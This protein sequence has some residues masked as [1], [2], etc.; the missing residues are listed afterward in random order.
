MPRKPENLETLRL[1]LELLQRIPRRGKITAKELHQ[2]INGAGIQR[3]TR[4]IQR[5][6]KMLTESF[7]IESDGAKPA[8]YRWKTHA[9]GMTVAAMS[10][11]QALLL[12]LAQQHLRLL[13]PAKV[14]EAMAQFF[15]QAQRN[16]DPFGDGKL[17]RQWLSKVRVVSEGVQLLPPKIAPGVFDTVSQ[18]L[19]GNFWLDLRYRNASGHESAVRVMPLGLAQQGPRMYLVCRYDGYANERSLALHRIVSAR[20]QT[21]SFERPRDFDLARYDDDGRFLFGEGQRV[22]LRFRI[23]TVCG[24]HLRETPLSKDQKIVEDGDEL[25][26]TA[27][28]VD[29]EYLTWWLRGFGGNVRAVRRRKLG[30][31][32][33]RK[34][35]AAKSKVESSE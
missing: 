16:L 8:G 4:T 33:D 15:E 21:L 17:A 13:L 32:G 22:E 23:A 2:Q 30:A 9:K 5:Q 19:Y 12:A 35:V 25:I 28:V 34:P 27:T 14:S 6:L 1:A 31:D 26:V 7:D 3:D 10:E 24:A 20:A 29:S 18:A 11:P